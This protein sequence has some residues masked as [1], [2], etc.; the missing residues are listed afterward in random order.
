MKKILILLF[1]F[2][3]GN[4]SI[5]QAPIGEY[6]IKTTGYGYS[7]RNARQKCGSY[8]LMNITVE[9][10]NLIELIRRPQ[11][12]SSYV[13]LNSNEITISARTKIKRFLFYGER[14][15]RNLRKCKYSDGETAKSIRAPYGKVLFDSNETN[16]NSGHSGFGSDYVTVYIRPDLK[17]LVDSEKTLPLDKFKRTIYSHT[18][19]DP[20]EYNWEYRI[21]DSEYELIHGNG[22]WKP[23]SQFQGQDKMH[24]KAEDF[25]DSTDFLNGDI[26]SLHGKYIG[27]RQQAYNYYTLSPPAIFVLSLSSPLIQRESVKAPSCLDSNDGQVTLVLDRELYDSE[28]ISLTLT[29]TSDLSN[30]NVVNITKDQVVNNRIVIDSLWPGD[31]EVTV[32]GAYG[33]PSTKTYSNTLQQSLDFQI[34]RPIP[35]AFTLNETGG[36]IFCYGGNDGYIHIK[37]TGGSNSYE[38]QL[39]GAVNWIPFSFRNQAWISN[40]TAGTYRIKVRDSNGCIAKEI[41]R[42]PGEP[43]ALG[44]EIVLEKTLT[45]PSA[46]L[47]LA[48][49][50]IYI[51]S[52]TFYMGTNGSITVRASGGTS[53]GSSGKYYYKW[54][55]EFGND[56]SHLASDRLE[57][58][59]Y[60][61]T[62]T[63]IGAG[64]YYVTLYDQN[65]ELAGAKKGCTTIRQEIIVTQP[66]ALMA[67]LEVVNEISCNNQNQYEN[68]SSDGAL[69]IIA[70]GGVPFTGFDN[71]SQPYKYFWK[72]LQADG[73]WLDLTAFTTDT[74]TGLDTGTYAVNIEDKNGI[75][76]G[77]YVNNELTIQQDVPYFLDQPDLLQ[78]SLSKTDVCVTADG[79]ITAT[80]SGG[81][82]PY[83]YQWSNGALTPT[84]AH[85]EEGVYR[86]LIT[87]SKGCQVEAERTVLPSL[88]IETTL[89]QEPSFAGGSNGSIQVKV[90]DGL[91]FADGSYAFTWLDENG[92]DI[93]HQAQGAVEA[94]DGSYRITL[95]G[96]AK[97][98]YTVKIQ[99][100]R[101]TD[102]A[103]LRDCYRLEREIELA[104][105]DPLELTFELINPISCHVENE[106]L[107]EGQE[108]DAMLRANVTGGRPFAPSQNGGLPYK[109][110][111]KKQQTDGSWRE[112][113]Q[114]TTETATHLNHGVYA[115]NVEDSNGIVL[116]EYVNNVLT[117]QTDSIYTLI[118]P[119]QLTMTLTPMDVCDNRLGWIT[120]EVEGGTPPYAFAWSNGATTQNIEALEAGSYSLTITD[121]RGCIVSA[122]AI[123]LAPVEVELIATIEPTFYQGTNGELIVRIS[124]GNPFA[125]GSYL[126]QWKDQDGNI[127]NSQVV[128]QITTEYFELKLQGIGKGEYNLTVWDNRDFGQDNH[129]CFVVE[130]QYNVTEPDPIVVE[131]ELLNDISC[132]LNN[133]YGNEVDSDQN[134][135]RDEAQDGA[136]RVNVSGGRPFQ[137][138]ENNNRPYKYTWKKQQQDGSW[139]ELY[140]FRSHEITN[141]SVGTYAVNVEDRNGIVL[142]TYV[143]NALQQKVD[144]LYSLAQ[145][146]ALTLTF[147]K[148]DSKCQG[149]LFGK[150]KAI[151]SGG[152]GPYTYEWSNG[153]STALIENLVSM[154]YYLIVYDS[155]G[156]RVEGVVTIEVPEQF[157]V[158][159]KVEQLQCHNETTASIALDVSGGVPPYTYTW[160]NGATTSSVHN[161]SAGI[162]TVEVRDTLGCGFIKEYEINNPQAFTFSLGEDVT[163]CEAQTLPLSIAIADPQATYSW[164]STN[165][166]QSTSS[167]V[168]LKEA[169]VYT[170]TIT[171]AKGCVASSQIE[172]KR[173]NVQ[174]SSEFLIATQAYIGEEV[175]IVNVSQPK[176]DQTTWIL[177]EGAEIIEETDHHIKL[178][179]HQ[180]GEYEIGLREHQGDCYQTFYKK[181]VVEEDAGYGS[182]D[183]SQ[184]PLIEEFIIAPVP[185]HGEFTV[186]VKLAKESPISLRLIN[187]ISPQIFYREE[188][189]GSKN[190]EI[191]VR[192]QVA[193]GLYIMIVETGGQTIRT[194]IIIL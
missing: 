12:N 162:Y 9:P 99:D 79:T 174:I 153:A 157:E 120:V 177:P 58:N 181:V 134:G 102:T 188:F 112:L 128:S 119:E 116:G 108:S 132:N 76:L 37:A 18:H 148:T 155:K 60:T 61:N 73:S 175:M 143:N 169:G 106:F 39:E 131:Y 184:G 100:A 150:A 139:Q 23:I 124:K 53:I 191:P 22:Y 56:M 29:N 178:V 193:A 190:Y 145:P 49:D 10:N 46:P 98:K 187:Y 95:R 133:I 16:N 122:S 110:T 82:A 109:Y 42:I 65:Y 164:T 147:E 129:A 118:Q 54:E 166:F 14:G 48:E 47:A 194:K 107:V 104:E 45:Q 35:V 123:V 165:G 86:V 20:V 41:V 32:I 189:S 88:K 87:D 63:G 80:V 27:I 3:V 21:A 156:C 64:K 55:D 125:D 70:S 115:V 127:R 141:L 24:T 163:L 130:K 140:N 15:Y 144:S 114:V 40:L 167:T 31:Y 34:K 170:A 182:G 30:S 171:T 173:M 28:I 78:V 33:N 6:K 96:V 151:V 13:D 84:L 52:P 83:T 51:Q 97:G 68:P 172:I 25:L 183:L 146:Q 138:G 185:N 74:A 43:D 180:V 36:N 101:Y 81:V 19:F 192:V 4:L 154:P 11:S 161:L 142:G 62:L 67:Q 71:N 57:L 186:Y 135:I 5:A 113:T 111:W 117:K 92:N 103:A 126:Y 121:S 2:L 94:T 168:E 44:E 105:P 90:W 26:K 159:E 93:T 1:V 75:R 85:L 66:E 17:V 77:V 8:V 69:R 149:D 160:N 91:T 38:Y 137:A 176:G 50:E 7:H 89:L 72:K 152:V 179:F 158:Q 59:T 136:L